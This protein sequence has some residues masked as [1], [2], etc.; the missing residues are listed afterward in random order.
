MTV[1][2][3]AVLLFHKSGSLLHHGKE[4]PRENGG[5]DA[6]RFRFLRKFPVGKADKMHRMALT[7]F[8]KQTQYMGLRTPDI[9]A[10]GEMHYIQSAHPLTFFLLYN[11]QRKMAIKSTKGKPLGAFLM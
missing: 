11:T 1:D 9:T 5:G 7:E 2:D 6:K 3:L 10:R 4:V 8:L